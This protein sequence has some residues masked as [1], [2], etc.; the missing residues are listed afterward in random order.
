MCV[1]V[2]RG[3]GDH[4]FR[5]PRNAGPLEISRSNYR[6]GERKLFVPPFITLIDKT[7]LWWSRLIRGRE[8]V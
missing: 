5:G 4:V 7:E 6:V 3:G 8:R 1:C 2:S